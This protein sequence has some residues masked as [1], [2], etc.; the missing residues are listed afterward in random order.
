MR[1]SRTTV[2]FALLAAVLAGAVS[3]SAAAQGVGPDPVRTFQSVAAPSLDSVL[4]FEESSVYGGPTTVWR[5]DLR[6]ARWERFALLPTEAGILGRL[7]VLPGHRAVYSVP[8]S[9]GGAGVL[10]LV[11]R[12]FRIRAAPQHRPVDV[13]DVAV[14]SRRDRI[15]AWSDLYEELWTYDPEQ[16]RWTQIKRSRPWP[17][18][19]L[20]GGGSGYT[21]MTY[22]PVV[23][24]AVLAVIPVPG[25][26]GATW[27]FDPGSGTW[28]RG[29]SAPPE[30]NYGYGEWATEAVYEPVHART[31]LIAWGTVATYDSARDSWDV[32]ST[33]QWPGIGHRPDGLRFGSLIRMDHQV[34]V[35]SR[36]GRVLMLGGSSFV[37]QPGVKPPWDYSWLP[38]R[39]V[40]AYDVGFNSW[41]RLSSGR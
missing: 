14:D 8:I 5:F 30:L 36:R 9:P 27:L 38:A 19:A 6:S 17:S 20:P 2:V 3:R 1:P 29:R 28:T 33:D 11:T 12:Q 34:A 35:D 18:A 13:S 24:R 32:P 41:T 40:W 22:D 39:D 37:H 4:A 31:V 7:A 23:D 25:R 26:S 10:D 16:N 15:L 21:Q